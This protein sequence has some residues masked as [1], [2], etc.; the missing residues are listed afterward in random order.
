MTDFEAAKF[1]M[2]F[3]RKRLGGGW[4]ELYEGVHPDYAGQPD[5]H[6][7]PIETLSRHMTIRQLV[8][9]FGSG[10]GEEEVLREFDEAERIEGKLQGSWEFM[11]KEEFDALDEATKQA[12]REWVESRWMGKAYD[13]PAGEFHDL[14]WAARTI[15]AYPWYRSECAQLAMDLSLCPMHY[16]DWAGCFDDDPECAQIRAVFPDSHDT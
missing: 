16:N 15:F 13:L 3:L 5:A 14:L 7:Y 1:A 4:S 2:A 12:R 8:I 10:D 11:S 9:G 6:H